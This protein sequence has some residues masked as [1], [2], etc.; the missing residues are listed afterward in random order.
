M[1]PKVKK[2]KGTRTVPFFYFIMASD[3][4]ITTV[5]T[6]LNEL[7]TDQPTDF[8]VS[9]KVKPTNNIKIFLDSEDGMSIEKCVKYNRKLY[10]KIEEAALFPDGNFSLEISSPGVDEPIKNH[11]QYLKNI[12]RTL[13]VTCQDETQKEGKLMEV[14]DS[15]ITIE[16]TTGKGK[17]AETHQHT[18]GI[19]NIKSAVVQ[20]QF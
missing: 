16:S 1:Y 9:L 2:M 11:R 17:K 8:L 19:E 15:A 10:H 20:V 14:T 13:L 6:M 5:E 7:L 3:P 18:I 12:G 4:L